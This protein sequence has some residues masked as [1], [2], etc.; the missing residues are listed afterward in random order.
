[1]Y[2]VIFL[3]LFS[4]LLILTLLGNSTTIA[5]DETFWSA[6]ELFNQAYKIHV[7]CTRDKYEADLAT[8]PQPIQEGVSAFFTYYWDYDLIVWLT[9]CIYFL[10]H[11]RNLFC[12][13]QFKAYQQ[14]HWIFESFFN[15][16]VIVAHTNFWSW[17]H[18]FPRASAHLGGTTSKAQSSTGQKKRR[19][20][21][22]G[23]AA[24]SRTPIISNSTGLLVA[25]C[26]TVLFA[27]TT[28][29]RRSSP[30][31]WTIVLPTSNVHLIWRGNLQH[32]PLE[33]EIVCFK[34]REN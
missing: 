15:R 32:I 24:S 10:S 5:S 33:V 19:S 2:G 8:Q 14:F 25:S 4:F 16:K 3:S 9:W 34:E 13:S 7:N 29:K 30:T 12:L 11:T 26:S 27:G 17:R 21:T 1:M 22:V 31:G 18:R 23:Q 6:P 20:R 28:T